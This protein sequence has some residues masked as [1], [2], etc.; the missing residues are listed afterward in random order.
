MESVRANEAA[1]KASIAQKAAVA[2][3]KVALTFAAASVVIAVVMTAADATELASIAGRVDPLLADTGQ[4]SSLLGSSV[5]VE[6]IRSK[7]TTNSPGT[8][9]DTA[10]TVGAAVGGG[11]GGLALLAFL[12]CWYRRHYKQAVKA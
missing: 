8:D 10:V 11:V 6:L 9:S 1:I 12:R 5:T 7:P 3:A 4:A 2:E